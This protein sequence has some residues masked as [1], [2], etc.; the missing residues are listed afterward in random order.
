MPNY[1]IAVVT[2]RFNEEV[3]EALHAGAC[4]RLQERGYQQGDYLDLQVPGA[5]ELP[6]V[7]K[8]LLDVDR[9]DAVICLGAVIRGETGHYDYVCQM[10]SQGCAELALTY[11]KPVIFGVLTTENKA[12]ALARAGG[13]KG[14]K[15][16][17][18]ADAALEM[19]EL[20]THI[21]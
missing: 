3:T 11:T 2:S 12:Q 14:N 6:V 13:A 8:K 7:A 1:R 5:V 20:L 9:V 21:K 15:G 4:Q 16:A 10:V 17:Y 19:C 18:A